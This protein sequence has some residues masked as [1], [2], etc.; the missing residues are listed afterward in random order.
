MT[1]DLVDVNI[2]RF[3]GTN[4]ADQPREAELTIDMF[5]LV[6]AQAVTLLEFIYTYL[7]PAGV[8]TFGPARTE[9]V[10]KDY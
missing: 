8:I 2:Y 10:N 9:V 1:L 5:G 7:E 4:E 6:V 3:L